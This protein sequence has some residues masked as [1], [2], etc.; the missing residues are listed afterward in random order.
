MEG[1][2]LTTDFDP[3]RRNPGSPE[4]TK[5]TRSQSQLAQSAIKPPLV[6]PRDTR[7]T[8]GSSKAVKAL[9]AVVLLS[10]VGGGVICVHALINRGMDS[11]KTSQSS[12]LRPGKTLNPSPAST[13]LDPAPDPTA[14]RTTPPSSLL[15]PRGTDTPTP[16]TGSVPSDQTT[17]SPRPT[18]RPSVPPTPVKPSTT[19][20]P[21]AEVTDRLSQQII[22]L[23]NTERLKHG[24]APV[25]AD[26]NLQIAAKAQSDEMAARNY[27]GHDIPDRADTGAIITSTGYKWIHWSQIIYKGPRDAEAAMEGWM[28]TP[29]NQ[30]AILN[31]SFRHVGVSVNFASTGPWW[32][33]VF[34]TPANQ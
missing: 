29:E 27:Y 3:F 18:L 6:A 20:N 15:Q 19:S 8:Q 21:T 25:S 2:P 1:S 17:D 23:T 31:C 5:P 12:T 24:C 30:A 10:V 22:A 7:G 28:K 14:G 11:A 33:Q 13:A 16:L 9:Q 4:N 32:T 26:P 34:A